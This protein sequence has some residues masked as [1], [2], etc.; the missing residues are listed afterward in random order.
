MTQRPGTDE[1]WIG[2]VGWGTWEEINRVVSPQPPHRTSAGRAT[3]EPRRRA[4]TRVPVSAQCS[5]LY[6]TPGS[7]VAPYYAYNHNAC[8]VSYPGCRTGGSSITGMAF[9]QGGS[10]PAQY[11]GALFFADHS[12]NEIWAMLPGHQRVARSGQAAVVRRCRRGRA[13]PPGIPST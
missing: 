9:Y 6:S 1:L 12:R 10:Y 4:V 8:V 11:N 5:S 3:R 13:V 2:D 7:V